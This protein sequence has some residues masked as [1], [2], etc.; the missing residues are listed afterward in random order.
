MCNKK[1][2]VLHGICHSVD[3]LTNKKIQYLKVNTYVLPINPNYEI[4][5]VNLFNQLFNQLNIF[6]TNTI[7]RNAVQHTY[8]KYIVILHSFI[9]WPLTT[10]Y[11]TYIILHYIKSTGSIISFICTCNLIHFTTPHQHTL[12]RLLFDPYLLQK[13]LSSSFKTQHTTVTQHKH[14]NNNNDYEVCRI[15]SQ[16]ALYISVR[17]FLPFRT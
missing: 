14:T 5:L 9:Q 12:L 1:T 8:V 2:I 7:S 6:L 16:S 11:L 15:C 17:R 3:C 10:Q 13:I 4:L